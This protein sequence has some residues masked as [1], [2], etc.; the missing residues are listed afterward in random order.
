MDENHKTLG[1]RIF[2]LRDERGWSQAR[3]A[4]EAG[5]SRATVVHLE[6]DKTRAAL[7]TLRRLSRALGVSVPEL[8]GDIRLGESRPEIVEQLRALPAEQIRRLLVGSWGEWVDHPDSKLTTAVEAERFA[9]QLGISPDEL[10]A[11]LKHIA[12]LSARELEQAAR[13]HRDA[14]AKFEREVYRELRR[15]TA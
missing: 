14:Q 5:I 13:R 4:E 3:L 2:E 8:R 15:P 6:G 7:P 12:P 1:E 9:K 10:R 11:A